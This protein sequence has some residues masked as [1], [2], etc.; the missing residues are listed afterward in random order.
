MKQPLTITLD[1]RVH[2]SQAELDQQLDAS[3]KV[4]SGLKASSDAYNAAA[5]L[6]TALADR[7]KSLEKLAPSEPAGTGQSGHSTPNAEPAKPAKDAVDALQDL[8]KKIAESR[9]E[10]PSRPESVP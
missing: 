1:P 2:V 7:Q 8:D 9:K 5:A 3:K 4:T 6:R 10:I